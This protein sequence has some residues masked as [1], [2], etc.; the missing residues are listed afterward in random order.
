M[1]RIRSTSER[2]GVRPLLAGLVAIMMVGTLAACEPVP[3]EPISFESGQGITVHGFHQLAESDR[4]WVVDISTPNVHAGAVNGFHQVFITLPTEYFDYGKRHYPVLYLLHGGGGGRSSDWTL[5]AGDAEAIT[6]PHRLIT[7]MPDGGK[8]GWYNDW[9]NTPE[10]AQAWQDFHLNQLI[11]WIDANLRTANHRLARG[12]AGLSM[13]GYGAIHYAQERP[14]LF[15][16]VASFSGAVDIEDFRVRAVV[17][18]QSAQHGFSANGPFGTPGGA[19]ST[20]FEDN[21]VNRATDLAGLDINIYTGPGTSV[22]DQIEYTMAANAK[23]LHDRLN[24]AGIDHFYW[25]YGRSPQISSPYQCDGSHNYGCWN[26]A[27]HHAMPNLMDVLI[28]P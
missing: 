23:T 2:N 16:Y 19:D 21:P 12:I 14:D 20:W 3:G 15:S 27:L 13:G 18:Q 4:T 7:V 6:E 25:N 8:V 5:G 24:E 10:G 1:S 9:V 26:F 22:L 28:G 11:P 17:A